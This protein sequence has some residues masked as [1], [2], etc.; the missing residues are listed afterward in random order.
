[1]KVELSESN[2]KTKKYA[3]KFYDDDGNYLKATNFGAEGYSDYTMHHDDNRKANY[4]ARHSNEDWTDPTK[5]GT[6]SRYILWNKK[7]IKESFDD[8][9]RKFKLKQL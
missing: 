6:L 7:T 5:A 3:M 2:N 1:M 9:I 4:I 8:Y